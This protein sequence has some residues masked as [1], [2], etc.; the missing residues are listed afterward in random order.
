MKKVEIVQGD[1]FLVRSSI[2]NGVKRVARE[3]RGYIL[4][5]GEVTGHAHVINECE[6][7]E[8][9]G[10][11]YIRIT[12]PTEITHEE[13]MPVIVPTGEWQV[14]IVREYDPFQEDARNVQD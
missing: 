10:V 11:L 9:G 13:H 1:V 7:Y 14:G 5:E 12:V 3:G 2:P 6:V 8:K 4:A